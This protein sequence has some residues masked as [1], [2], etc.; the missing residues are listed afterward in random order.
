MSD[1]KLAAFIIIISAIMIIL[2][3]MSDEI[4]LLPNLIVSSVLIVGTLAAIFTRK[5]EEKQDR[6]IDFFGNLINWI[7]G[8]ALLIGCVILIVSELFR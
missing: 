6:V 7:W 1:G 3:L 2:P 8:L 4:P 5:N